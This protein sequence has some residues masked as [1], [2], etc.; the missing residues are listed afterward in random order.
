[1]IS[2]FS[3]LDICGLVSFTLRFES[4]TEKADKQAGTHA[5]N[6]KAR[7]SRSLS[8]AEVICSILF[9][10]D[11]HKWA[12][13]EYNAEQTGWAHAR[14]MHITPT[15]SAPCT[16]GLSSCTSVAASLS[17]SCKRRAVAEGAG[18]TSNPAV[19]V[20]TPKQP[21]WRKHQAAA[22]E[23]NVCGNTR[24]VNVAG[25]AGRSGTEVSSR[26]CENR[27]LCR[28]ARKRGGVED[29][30]EH[31]P[32]SQA[33]VGRC[34]RMY[35]GDGWGAR[36]WWLYVRACV[37]MDFSTMCARLY[38][39]PCGGSRLM[40]A[41]FSGR[42]SFAYLCSLRPRI[43]LSNAMSRPKDAA[44]KTIWQ[45]AESGDLEGVASQL[46]AGTDVNARDEE[47]RTALLW[48]AGKGHSAVVELLLKEGADIH[49]RD[50]EGRTALHHVAKVTL[51]DVVHNRCECYSAT[52][53]L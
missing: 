27:R 51:V 45:A 43:R 33:A 25:A 46:K 5:P 1:M 11:A 20:D 7:E 36:S 53:A 40:P 50:N 22:A 47:K 48:A 21:H 31:N 49:V 44:H 12:L 15:R 37:W 52:F 29:K 35:A 32:G 26:Q 3:A 18:A 42:L 23:R 24:A 9:A 19:R 28:E 39:P 8:V 17:C 38:T 14:C 4:Q 2:I 6:E 30:Q 34:G 41:E 13:G 16:S 10:V